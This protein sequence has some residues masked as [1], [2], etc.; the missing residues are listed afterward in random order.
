MHKTLDV[1]DKQATQW[2]RVPLPCFSGALSPGR[3]TV[4][5]RPQLTATWHNSSR[6]H[7]ISAFLLYILWSAL[8]H[9]QHSTLT[10]EICLAL[11]PAPLLDLFLLLSV[12]VMERIKCLGGQGPRWFGPSRMQPDT[13][14]EAAKSHQWA[15]ALFSELLWNRGQKIAIKFKWKLNYLKKSGADCWA[16]LKIHAI[17][18]WI[19][20]FCK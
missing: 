12:D 7:S 13:A 11:P 4:H 18:S 17:Q 14:Q 1:G 6:F 20:H 15:V 9:L 5:V 8:G 19:S 2:S 10:E 3:T 16:M